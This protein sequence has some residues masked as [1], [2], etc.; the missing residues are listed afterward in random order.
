MN[1]NRKHKDRLFTFLFG[2]EKNKDKTLA[3]YNALNGTDYECVD[4]LELK[5]MDDAIYMGM[6]NDVAFIIYNDLSLYEHQ[7]TYNPNMPV[8]GFMY[9]GKLYSKYIEE[10]DLSIYGKKLV[11]LPSPHYYVFY[12]G[13]EEHP[14][15]EELKLSDAFEDFDSQG[16]FEWTAVMLNINYGRNKDLMEKCQPLQEYSILISKIRKYEKIEGSLEKAID[17]AVDE[18]IEEDILVDFL[19]G[20]RAE[21]KE[22]VLTEYDEAKTM[23]ALAK[24]SEEIGEERGRNDERIKIAKKLIEQ[25]VNDEI[26]CASTGLSQEEVDKLKK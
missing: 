23:K 22:M 8:R 24:E 2:N 3:L 15:R 21:V 10:N 16:K 25:K 17:R 12:N 14:D 11:K 19:K 6:K 20:H 5:T 1:I 13:T 9:A 4:D 7:S 18:C 26:I